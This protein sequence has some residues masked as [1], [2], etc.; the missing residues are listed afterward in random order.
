M[1]NWADL[2]DRVVDAA[3]SRVPERPGQWSTAVEQL[4]AMVTEDYLPAGIAGESRTR[5]DGSAVITLDARLTQTRRTF[6][7]AHEL[8]HLMLNRSSVVS[9]LGDEIPTG[10]AAIE[11]LCDAIAGSLLVPRS[12]IETLRDTPPALEQML[13]LAKHLGMSPSVFAIRLANHDRH[14]LLLNARHHAGQWKW[15]YQDGYLPQV[16]ARKLNAAALDAPNCEG[17]WRLASTTLHANS[18][19]NGTTSGGLNAH[20]DS[21]RFFISFN[22]PF[23]SPIDDSAEWQECST[24]DWGARVP[25]PSGNSWSIG[26]R[27]ISESDLVVDVQK[28]SANALVWIR[29]SAWGTVQEDSSHWPIR[30]EQDG[31]GA[32]SSQYQSGY[33]SSAQRHRAGTA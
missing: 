12:W 6:T 25:A 19:A 14:C 1:R 22:R 9:L 3:L 11:A 4:N 27:A 30:E 21:N 2:A 20:R 29:P 17:T 15:R 28:S 7:A 8:G 26:A 13:L 23:T 32:G 5:R 16:Y 10:A 18:S 24:V 31:R 33:S